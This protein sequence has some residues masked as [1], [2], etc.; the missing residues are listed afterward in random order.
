MSG[1]HEILLGYGL[2]VAAVTIW[3]VTCILWG[4]DDE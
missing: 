1:E 4:G 3:I 2:F